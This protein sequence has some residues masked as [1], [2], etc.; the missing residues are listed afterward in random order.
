VPIAFFRVQKWGQTIKVKGK[1]KV[2]SSGQE[3]PLH[4][5]K[6]ASSSIVPARSNASATPFT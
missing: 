3:C 5:V 2:N 1:I 4:T 6:S